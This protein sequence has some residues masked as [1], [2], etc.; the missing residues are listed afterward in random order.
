M[1]GFGSWGCRVVVLGQ[2]F[3]VLYQLDNFLLLSCII[4]YFC[5]VLKLKEKV[6]QRIGQQGGWRELCGVGRRV[7]G[8]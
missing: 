8:V 5:I 1:Q 2:N 6:E 7:V 3:R 4:I